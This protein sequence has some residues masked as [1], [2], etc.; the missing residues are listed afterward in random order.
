MVLSSWLNFEFLNF[1]SILFLSEIIDFNRAWFRF[2]HS[3]YFQMPIKLNIF[4]LQLMLSETLIMFHNNYQLLFSWPFSSENGSSPNIKIE[5][6]TQL[7]KPEVHTLSKF[8]GYLKISCINIYVFICQ[9]ESFFAIEGFIHIIE[10]QS[11]EARGLPMTST[12][13]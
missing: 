13:I 12:N 8:V 10:G 5:F 7:L 2:S 9:K 11:K 4:L 6:V 1:N 3:P